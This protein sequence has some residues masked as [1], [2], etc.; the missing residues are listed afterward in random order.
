MSYVQWNRFNLAT[1]CSVPETTGCR[2]GRNTGPTSGCIR[3]VTRGGL[4]D[5]DKLFKYSMLTLQLQDEGV[6][7]G[8]Y[9]DYVPGV[10]SRPD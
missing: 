1:T 8:L 7:P 3:Q 9:D 4:S 2:D 5:K 6:Q 10:S